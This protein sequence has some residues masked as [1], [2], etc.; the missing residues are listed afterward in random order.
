M[1]KK[2]NELT[3]SDDF[4]FGKVLTTNKELC[5]ELLELILGE[6]INRIEF[7]EAQ[8]TLKQTYLSKGIRL[9]K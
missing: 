2:F 3:F 8:R 1:I 7:V 5:K 6:K 9:D 4:M